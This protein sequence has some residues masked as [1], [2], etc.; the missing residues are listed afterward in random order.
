MTLKGARFLASVLH[1]IKGPVVIVS[2]VKQVGEFLLHNSVFIARSRVQVELQIA[3]SLGQAALSI[4][5]GFA[6]HVFASAD[7]VDALK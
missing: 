2:E 5:E 6:V 4:E 3:I 1:F 7:L